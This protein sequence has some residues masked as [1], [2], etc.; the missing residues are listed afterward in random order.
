MTPTANARLA[1]ATF[2]VYIV[3]GIGS[4]LLFQP[5]ASAPRG[6]RLMARLPAAPEARDRVAPW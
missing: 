5:I 6:K 4:M 2:L 3:T 1:G